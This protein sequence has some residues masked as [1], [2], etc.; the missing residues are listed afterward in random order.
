M[1]KTVKY[2]FREPGTN[3]VKAVVEFWISYEIVNEKIKKNHVSF[4]VYGPGEFEWKDWLHDWETSSNTHAV[5][6]PSEV[7]RLVNKYTGS[8]INYESIRH[9]VDDIIKNLQRQHDYKLFQEEKK[10][11]K[12]EVQKAMTE[13]IRKIMKKHRLAFNQEYED[14]YD[15]TNYLFKGE[16][17]GYDFSIYL[18]DVLESTYETI[19]NE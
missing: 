18:D 9:T 10:N 3:K 5:Y 1:L 4:N 13:S 2:A 8:S 14:S 12:E 11:I 7:A 6:K 19:K 16:S 15:I 17:H